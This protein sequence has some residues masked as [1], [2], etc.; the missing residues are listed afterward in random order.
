MNGTDP[1]VVTNSVLS[2]WPMI[3]WFTHWKWWFSTHVKLP[4]CVYGCVWKCCVPMCTPLYPMVLLIIIPFL[5]GYFIGN[6]YPIFRHTQLKLPLGAK[7]PATTT[8]LGPNSCSARS[9][10]FSSD[11][12]LRR[13]TFQ[14]LGSFGPT[15]LGTSSPGKHDETLPGK[16]GKLW[17]ILMW[18]EKSF[19]FK[20]FARKWK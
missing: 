14:R 8:R 13:E 11:T 5:N 1:L 17:L 4:E 20:L 6:I 19:D 3:R 2:K 9:C 15:L 18:G 10:V 12:P 7:S 16:A